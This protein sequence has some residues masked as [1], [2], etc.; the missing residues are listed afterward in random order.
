MTELQQIRSPESY[1]SVRQLLQLSS[2]DLLETLT[3]MDRLDTFVQSLPPDD[4]FW[5]I[6]RIGADDALA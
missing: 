2:G 1:L 6:K 3:G 5:L 4:F